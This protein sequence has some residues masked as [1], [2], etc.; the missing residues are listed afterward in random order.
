MKSSVPK[1]LNFAT[2][3]ALSVVCSIL[4]SEIIKILKL[5]WVQIF[6]MFWI[7]L[8]QIGH[9][10]ALLYNNDDFCAREYG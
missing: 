1:I 10:L 9:K 8:A 3:L 5:F 4:L 6:F 7:M 2:F